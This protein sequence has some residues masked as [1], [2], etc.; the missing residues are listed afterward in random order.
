MRTETILNT[1]TNTLN[2]Y[3]MLRDDRT[4]TDLINELKAEVLSLIHI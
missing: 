2:D 1:L 4:F 3:P